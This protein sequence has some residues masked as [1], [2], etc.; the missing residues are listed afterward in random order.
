[1]HVAR[2]PRRFCSCRL[3][4]SAGPGRSRRARRRLPRRGPQIA[5]ERGVA[6]RRNGW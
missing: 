2:H 4:P 5:A 6:Y 1:M 3:P